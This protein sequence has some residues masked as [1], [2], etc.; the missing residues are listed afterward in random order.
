MKIARFA[1]KM[2]KAYWTNDKYLDHFWNA[3]F[4]IFLF[5]TFVKK[6]IQ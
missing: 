6:N 1:I 4:K 2:L 5:G 3:I